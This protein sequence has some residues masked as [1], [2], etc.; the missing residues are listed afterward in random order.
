ML[1]DMAPASGADRPD[2]GSTAALD[3]APQSIII[4][5]PE[6]HIAYWNRASEALYGW[7][8]EQALGKELN[9]FLGSRHSQPLS[10]LQAVPGEK[11]CWDG[12]LVRTT[13]SGAVRT[14]ETRWAVLPGA[15]AAGGR[16]IEYGRDITELTDAEQSVQLLTHRYTNLFQ[17]MAA[18]FRELDFTE[19][20]KMIGEL[21]QM[22]VTDVGAYFEDHPEFIDLAISRTRIVDVNDK[23]VGL[24]GGRDRQS[25]IGMSVEPF[26]P[27]ESRDVYAR[28]LIAAVR[29]EPNLQTETR[30][31]TLDGRKIDALFTVCWPEGHHGRGTVLVGVIDLSDRVRAE[32]ELR[33]SELRY[34]DLFQAMSTALF[35]LDTTGLL[36]FYD[37]LEAKG[38]RDLAEYLDEHPA[39]L[40]RAMSGC[41]IAEVNAAAVKLLGARSPDDL[42]GKSVAHFWPPSG[43][44]AFRAAIEQSFRS[45]GP[46]ETHAR[47]RRLDGTE[48]DSLFMVN[49][50]PILRARKMTLVGLVDISGE[51]EA[52][53]AIQRLQADYAHASRLTVLGELAASIAHEVNQ[54]LA[55]IA[56]NGAAA[57][58]WLKRPE[59]DL[60]ELTDINTAMI[61]DAN[62]A[63]EI[64]ARIRSLAAKREGRFLPGSINEIVQEALVFLAHELQA[65]G[66]R[67]RTALQE[68]LPEVLVDRV[69]IQQ[70]VVNLVLNAMQEMTRK[71]IPVPL[72]EVTSSF[73]IDRVVIRVEDT[74]TGIAKDM[75]EKVF[76][77][78]YTT[79]QTGLGIGLAIC[80]NIVDG[81]GG[82]SLP[83]ILHWA[84]RASR[85][86]CRQDVHKSPTQERGGSCPLEPLRH[87][88]ALMMKSRRP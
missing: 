2:I 61:A 41:T 38:V 13:A 18:S 26:W 87:Q 84:E 70:V 53:H 51:V 47:N 49:A 39:A 76:E 75:R 37:E 71:N 4:C 86:N 30:L 27:G 72:I 24:F 46:F 17:A 23:T 5:G 31:S 55:A 74:G 54:P 60:T 14:V 78:F 35:Q 19:V 22:G 80:R 81:H 32:E 42:I 73:A 67:T 56:A 48:F 62:R 83:I 9:V 68:G 28:S 10:L 82:G 52:R 58:R 34:R 63:A 77:S 8:S 66:M 29:R 57:G 45:A 69:Q 85:L 25:M 11:K 6:W 16:F 88:D 43:E 79:K 12:E 21:L 40:K 3:H 65:H 44:N 59:P 1:E 7:T 36:A 20:R 50:S 15:G 33:Q 64:V